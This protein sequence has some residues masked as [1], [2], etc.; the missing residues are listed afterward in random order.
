MQTCDDVGKVELYHVDKL[1]FERVA[2]LSGG[3]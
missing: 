2:G 1:E 3:A